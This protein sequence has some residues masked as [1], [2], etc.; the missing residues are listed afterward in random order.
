MSSIISQGPS[1]QQYSQQ[2]TSPPQLKQI[3]K[4]V[5]ASI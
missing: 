1:E 4:H 5:V 2:P 3:L